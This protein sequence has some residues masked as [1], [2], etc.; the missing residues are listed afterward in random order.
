M[1]RVPDTPPWPDW[2]R[3]AASRAGEPPW[4]QWAAGLA[5]GLDVAFRED[6]PGI[7]AAAQVL[8]DGLRARPGPVDL[9]LLQ[10]V[11]DEMD[12]GLRAPPE[13]WRVMETLSDGRSRAER[14]SLLAGEIWRAGALPMALAALIA[15]TDA[16]P[17]RRY[18]LRL[19]EL[20]GLIEVLW[21]TLKG[22]GAPDAAQ[23]ATLRR[24]LDDLGT[25]KLGL[26]EILAEQADGGARLRGWLCVPAVRAVWVQAGVRVAE[27]AKEL[28]LDVPPAVELAEALL[29]LVQE[30]ERAARTRHKI[31]PLRR[32]PLEGDLRRALAGGLE[33]LREAAPEWRESWEVLRW[34]DDSTDAR[35][36]GRL[37]PQAQV[38]HALLAIGEP[39][40]AEIVKFLD[41]LPE[42]PP[43]RYEAWFGLPPDSELLGLLLQLAA[44]LPEPPRPKVEAWIDVLRA[45]AAPDGRVPTWLQRGPGGGLLAPDL[46]RPG[47]QCTG[48]ALRLVAGISAWDPVGSWHL[49][50]STLEDALNAL[51][52]G[53]PAQGCVLV[54]VAQLGPL[55]LDVQRLAPRIMP[56]A[57][58]QALRRLTQR[59]RDGLGMDGG[60]ELALLERAAHVELL[61][62]ERPRWG[63]GRPELRAALRVLL[64]AQRAD[65]SWPEAPLY[66]VPLKVPTTG[67]HGGRLLSTAK[68]LRALAAGRAVLQAQ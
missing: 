48:A 55:M 60:R 10:R 14:Q 25:R 68:V 39:V 59:A 47:R 38:L 24:V 17:W 15:G 36:E 49:A 20:V 45:S 11:F 54:D 53:G 19:A 21:L 42:G 3:A 62:S 22:A 32:V 13:R 16:A 52:E 18:G 6:A 58:V 43:R 37:L 40:E 50:A 56:Q 4:G 67:W 28:A 1:P 31:H 41:D 8:A 34:G 7:A 66:A 5:L 23:R 61:A 29:G 63:Q 30:L 35:L 12:R 51:S 9:S 44:S 57:Q 27:S 33:A 26:L 64:E 2:P 65:G 46:P